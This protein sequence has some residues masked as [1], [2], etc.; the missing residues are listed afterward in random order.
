[1]HRKYNLGKY[2]GIEKS[3]GHISPVRDTRYMYVT[4]EITCK[5]QNM[6]E[7]QKNVSY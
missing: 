4:H 3:N 5:L 6:Q 7:S 2:T 1:M